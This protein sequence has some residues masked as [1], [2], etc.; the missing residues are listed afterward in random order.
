R[1]SVVENEE[2]NENPLLRD[3]TLTFKVDKGTIVDNHDGTWTITMTDDDIVVSVQ[4]HVSVEIVKDDNAANDNVWYTISGIRLTEKPTA[5]G[6]YIH[7]GK[8]VLVK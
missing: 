6:I 1:L 8:K 3:E 2:N 4:H 7:N 5:A